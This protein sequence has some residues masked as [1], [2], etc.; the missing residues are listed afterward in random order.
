M[1]KLCSTYSRHTAQE[2]GLAKLEHFAIRFLEEKS[3]K[4]K[5]RFYNIGSHIAAYLLKTL[6]AKQRTMVSSYS[7]ISSLV[8]LISTCHVCQAY[9][10]PLVCPTTSPSNVSQPLLSTPPPHQGRHESISSI[11]KQRIRK[12]LDSHLAYVGENAFYEKVRICQGPFGSGVIK[13]YPRTKHKYTVC[14]CTTH[15]LTMVFTLLNWKK[16]K[17]SFIKSHAYSFVIIY[18]Y[19]LTIRVGMGSL[20]YVPRT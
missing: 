4:L 17:W 18:A 11:A 16:I 10:M 5:P 6:R 7:D 3:G 8:Y 20:L 2:Q 1:V 15:E 14:F 13:L 12:F 9:W 19:F